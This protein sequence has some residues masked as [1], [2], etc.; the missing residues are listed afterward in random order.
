VLIKP[1][2]QP[3]GSPGPPRQL[4]SGVSLGE[5][6]HRRLLFRDRPHSP[7]AWRSW[8]TDF[9]SFGKPGPVR[10]PPQLTPTILV[11][12]SPTTRPSASGTAKNSIGVMLR[13]GSDTHRRRMLNCRRAPSRR[14][15]PPDRMRV[16]I[17]GMLPAV[18]AT[19]TAQLRLLILFGA[20]CVSVLPRAVVAPLPRDDYALD[21]CGR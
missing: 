11:Q 1:P 3:C 19:T 16:L 21:A 18:M 6:P 5:A 15:R 17:R 20:H 13:P 10:R 14:L 2:A 8:R 7:T 9:E 12:R 4:R